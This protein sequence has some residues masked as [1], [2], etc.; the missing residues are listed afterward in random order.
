MFGINI[1]IASSTLPFPDVRPAKEIET[2]ADQTPQSVAFGTTYQDLELPATVEVTFDDA[3]T[4][5]LNVFWQ[6]N[7]YNATSPTDHTI[8]GVIQLIPDT[9]NTAGVLATILVTVEEEVHDVVSV[10]TQANI[11]VP[12]TTAFEDIALPSTVNVT[13]DDASVVAM[14]VTWDEGSYDP[15]VEDTYPITGTLTLPDHVA[16][17][18]SVTAAINIV[19]V[20]GPG[21]DRDITS[22][23]TQTSRTFAY[24]TAFATVQAALPSTVN[25]TLDDGSVIAISV[26]WAQGSYNQTTPGTY[27]IVGTLGTL[28]QD[29]TN[30]DLLQAHT[31]VILQ[32]SGATE[33]GV[34]VKKPAGTTGAAIGYL[35]FLPND[36]SQTVDTYPCIIFLHGAGERGVGTSGDLDKV[37]ANGPPKHIKNGSQMQF[38]GEKFI[39]L[40]PQANSWFWTEAWAFCDWVKES[41]GYRIDPNRIYL[42]GLS[43][44]GYGTWLASANVGNDPNIFAAIAP[45]CASGGTSASWG[46][47]AANKDIKVW[48]FAGDADTAAPLAGV[49]RPVNGMIA[50]GA[51]VDINN[52]MTAG[53]SP[54]SIFT[55]YAGAGH[56]QTWDKAYRVGHEFHN[57]NLYE[58]LLTK[59]L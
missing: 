28:P 40:S 48:A 15:D 18:G 57:P 55:I 26:T 6:Q 52:S 32:P 33:D 50:A 54:E 21:D 12:V 25:C 35:Q 59:S 30:T 36:Y 42:T 22:I 49:S 8:T 23:A 16:N 9:A 5:N 47:N 14:E 1:G 37:P 17:P 51:V 13:L 11:T 4:A 39:V 31:S 10:A 29:I 53:N 46:T 56:S 44:G 24:N 27:D 19:V 38:G 2:V 41:S 3:S 43:M 45:V 34:Q 58:W 20:D 7:D